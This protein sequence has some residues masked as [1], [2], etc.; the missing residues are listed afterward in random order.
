MPSISI[1]LLP[2]K[3]G[4]VAHPK[5]GHTTLATMATVWKLPYQCSHREP[6]T[7]I[8]EAESFV[9]LWRNPKE[10]IRS[11]LSSAPTS[12]HI[13]RELGKPKVMDPPHLFDALR[14]IYETRPMGHPRRG[15]GERIHIAPVVPRFKS[16]EATGKP[17]TFFPLSSLSTLMKA[18]ETGFGFDSEGAKGWERGPQD[19]WKTFEWNVTLNRSLMDG[20]EIPRDIVKIY[21]EDF[22]FDSIFLKASTNNDFEDSAVMR[23]LLGL[24]PLPSE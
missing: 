22:D 20:I 8:E 21:Q 7:L 1:C 12:H 17:I 15:F 9:I 14:K 3:V 23:A 18:I 16:F 13:W 10:R 4:I 19:K 24:V 5:V 6:L 11:L 2:S